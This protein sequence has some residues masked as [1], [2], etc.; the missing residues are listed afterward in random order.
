MTLEEFKKTEKKKRL[1]KLENFKNEI[2]EL[3]NEGYSLKTIIRFLEKKGVKTC[4]SN[5]LSFLKR[6]K[7]KTEFVKNTSIQTE[8][9]SPVIQEKEDLF[10]V[11]IKKDSAIAEAIKNIK[12]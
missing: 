12:K 4:Q 9:D 7:Y 2:F 1:S 8:E 5:L 3:N 6:R 11:K 10:K